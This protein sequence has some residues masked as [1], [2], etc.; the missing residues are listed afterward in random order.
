MIKEIEQML[1][2]GTATTKVKGKPRELHPENMPML[3]EFYKVVRLLELSMNAVTPLLVMKD[4]N[5][6]KPSS[7]QNIIQAFRRGHDPIRIVN[8]VTLYDVIDKFTE[9]LKLA[10]RSGKFSG[11]YP[12]QG[13]DATDFI[14]KAISS[15]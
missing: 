1:E 8:K 13:K 9:V 7:Y 15:I 14:K 4:Y 12:K 2:H 6:G 11:E 3:L 5:N 10:I